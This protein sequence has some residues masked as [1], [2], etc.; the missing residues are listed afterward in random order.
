METIRTEEQRNYIGEYYKK[1]IHDWEKFFVVNAIGD[2]KIDEITKAIKKLNTELDEAEGKLAK[3]YSKKYSQKYVKPSKSVYLYYTDRGGVKHYYSVP[4]G[5]GVDESHVGNAYLTQLETKSGEVDVL[6]GFCYEL[7]SVV[8]KTFKY[9]I[10]GDNNTVKLKLI[11]ETLSDI[12]QHKSVNNRTLSVTDRLDYSIMRNIEGDEFINNLYGTH[13]NLKWFLHEYASR[14]NNN[15]SF[16]TI[17]KTAPNE[18]VSY[19]LRLDIKE[20]MAIYKIMGISK[21]C[22][23]DSISRNIVG[24]V[25]KLRDFIGCKDVFNK[26]ENEWMDLIETCKRYEEDL[27]FYDIE[28]KRYS[29]YNCSSAPQCSHALDTLAYEYKREDIIRQYY[30]FG[31]FVEY[32]IK[33]CIDQGYS[34]LDN[35]ICEL[36]DYLSMCKRQG[37][38]PILFSNC[39]KQTHDITARNHKIH[40]TPEDELKFKAQYDD[41]KQ[42]KCEDYVVVA[43]EKSDDLKAEGDNLNHCVASYIKKVIDGESLIFFLRKDPAISL[44]TLQIKDGKIIQARG[45]HNRQPNKEEVAAVEKF[46]EKQKLELAY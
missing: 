39:L 41:F 15:K 13:I 31:K 4:D 37:V 3:E 27:N 7:A 14:I 9:T 30:S 35:F 6:A 33:G 10:S 26:T 18:I 28:C 29:Y 1:D 19:L 5:Q 2:D 8:S 46:A 34:S 25:Y 21:E 32:V 43:P 12:I 38:K 22:Y 23:N 11:Q 20:P 16:E 45:M 17:I 24:D 42:V 36:K 44:L 40:V